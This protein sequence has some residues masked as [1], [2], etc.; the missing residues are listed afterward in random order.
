MRIYNDV[1]STHHENHQAASRRYKLKRGNAKTLSV[2]QLILSGE[3]FYAT[4]LNILLLDKKKKK[5]KNYQCKKTL[6][7]K[8]MT[9]NHMVMSISQPT[10]FKVTYKLRKKPTVI[11]CIKT[12]RV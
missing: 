9:G 2:N 6:H 3:H 7:Q 12:H 5:K 4:V 10:T 8:V 1:D 11:S